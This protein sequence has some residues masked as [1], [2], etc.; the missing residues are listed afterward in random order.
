MQCPC[1]Q[2]WDLPENLGPLRILLNAKMFSP[3][4][5][6]RFICTDRACVRVYVCVCGGGAHTH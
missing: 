4:D 3:G 5:D 2:T 1:A 6:S